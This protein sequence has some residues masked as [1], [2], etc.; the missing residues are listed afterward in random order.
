M[1]YDLIKET[2]AWVL[3]H[4][5]MW[6]QQAQQFRF[7][8][9][10]F[11]RFVEIAKRPAYAIPLNHHDAQRRRSG[12]RELGLRLSHA[13]LATGAGIVGRGGD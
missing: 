7:D 5:Y 3:G 13:A 11:I 4:C 12:K 9:P 1:N 8:T 2:H 6:N 10:D